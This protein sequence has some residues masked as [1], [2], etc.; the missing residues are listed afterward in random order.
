EAF[1]E[2]WEPNNN[3]SFL[4]IKAPGMNALKVPLTK[5]PQIVDGVSVWEWSGTAMDEGAAAAQ[6]FSDYLG[7]PTRLVRFRDVAVR[8]VDPNYA[9]GY[10][11]MFSDLFPF[12]VLSQVNTL[13][14]L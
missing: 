4:V 3:N 7:K 13:Y 9:P 2:G 12:L 8:D 6:W 1:V 11:V 5:P 10:K 14:L